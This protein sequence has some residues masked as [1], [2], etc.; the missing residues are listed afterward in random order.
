VQSADDTPANVTDMRLDQWW[1]F[2]FDHLVA[3][4]DIRGTSAAAGVT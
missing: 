4:P 3:L 1:A 2:S